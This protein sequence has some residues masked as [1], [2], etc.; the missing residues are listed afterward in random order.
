MFKYLGQNLKSDKDIV[1][2]VTNKIPYMFCYAS[3]ELKADID[4]ILTIK[5]QEILY[6]ISDELYENSEFLVQAILHW[7]LNFIE[8][9]KNKRLSPNY[10]IA[11]KVI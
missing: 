5:S 3:A 11:N 10:P 7:E 8:I 2:V 9:I 1:L 6:Y 4:F